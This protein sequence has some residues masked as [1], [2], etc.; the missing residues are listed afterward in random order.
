[1]PLLTTITSKQLTAAGAGLLDL[2]PRYEDFV[3]DQMGYNEGDTITATVTSKFINDNTTVNYTS[4]GLSTNDLTSGSLSGTFTI[5]NNTA[6]VQFVL[7]NDGLTEGTDNFTITLAASDSAGN[8]TGS[9]NATAPIADTSNDPTRTPWLDDN[10]DIV[11][12][13]QIISPVA[14]QLNAVF[15]TNPTVPLTIEGRTSGATTTI[16]NIS[17]N[18]GTILEIDDNGNSTNFTVSEELNL[19]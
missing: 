8:L 7:A 19:V 13:S 4:T 12:V 14:M 5:V 15:A 17:A 6:S 3:L 1:M 2:T 16:T 11:T 10:D 9:I 18:T